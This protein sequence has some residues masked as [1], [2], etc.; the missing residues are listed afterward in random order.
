MGSEAWAVARER[1]STTCVPAGRLSGAWAWIW[2]FGGPGGGTAMS[3]KVT[4]EPPRTVGAGIVSAAA[5]PARLVPLM[6]MNEPGRI[7]GVPSDEFTMPRA[8][9][10][11]AGRVSP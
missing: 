7:L 11:I 3:P 6:V 5:A 2:P 4:Q 10:A 9:A 1:T 8:P